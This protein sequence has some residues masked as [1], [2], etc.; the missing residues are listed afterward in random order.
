MTDGDGDGDG[1]DDGDAS[2][3]FALRPASRP[4]LEAAFDH[5]LGRAASSNDGSERSAENYDT[6]A[7]SVDEPWAND[8]MAYARTRDFGVSHDHLPPRADSPPVLDPPQLTPPS[9][10]VALVFCTDTAGARHAQTRVFTDY[11]PPLPPAS[12]ASFRFNPHDDANDHDDEPP[13]D[14]RWNDRGNFWYEEQ[15]RKCRL[16]ALVETGRHAGRSQVKMRGRS[17][18]GLWTF[19][20][21]TSMVELPWRYLALFVSGLYLFSF[22]LRVVLVRFIEDRRW[23][24]GGIFPRRVQRRRDLQRRHADDH[25]LRHEAHRRNVSHG[26]VSVTDAVTR[27]GFRRRAEPRVDLRENHRSQ[28]SDALRVH[29]GRRVRGVSRR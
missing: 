3:W 12:V 23:V 27:W 15:R 26:N 10:E 6:V 4:H 13:R 29:L 24:R 17:L 18:V 1:N 28:T 16:P 20:M 19:D 11:A 9:P 8:G 5:G 2:A 21:F 14:I 7:V 22:A 25:R